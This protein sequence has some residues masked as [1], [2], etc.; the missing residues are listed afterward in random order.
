MIDIYI[1]R[2][3]NDRDRDRDNTDRDDKETD[4]DRDDR[5]KE[6]IENIEMIEI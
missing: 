5:N 4:R 2:D 1:E 6:M 3:L